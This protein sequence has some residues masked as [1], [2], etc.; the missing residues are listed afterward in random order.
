MQI[1]SINRT[2]NYLTETSS[3]RDATYDIHY[4][5]ED[6]ASRDDFAAKFPKY[7]KVK[8]SGCSGYGA[9]EFGVLINLSTPTNLVTGEINETAE[10][11]VKK[12]KQ[13]LSTIPGA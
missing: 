11:R 5:F 13:I 1:S 3:Y 8:I 2:S 7:C 4:K 10:K 9:F 6:A 12:I